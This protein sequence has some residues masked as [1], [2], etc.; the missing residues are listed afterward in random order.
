MDL[1]SRAKLPSRT[2]GLP[3][4]TP[5][6]LRFINSFNISNLMVVNNTTLPPME[7]QEVELASI[8]LQANHTSKII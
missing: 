1:L 4:L 8:N 3:E 2:Q 6:R 7:G 5:L